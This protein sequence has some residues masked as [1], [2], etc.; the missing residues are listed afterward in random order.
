MFVGNEKPIE[1]KPKRL[2]FKH[3]LWKVFLEDWMIKVLALAITL[4]LWFGVT[5]LS[6]PTTRRLSGI[7]LT[8]LISN[9]SEITN[10]PLR[11]VDLVVSGDKR[12]VDQ[13]NAGDLAVSVDLSDTIPGDRVVQ[14]TPQGVSVSLPTG[15]KLD[16]L[17]P[18]RIAVKLEA[19]EEK[20]IPVQVVTEGAAAPGSAV[21]S[22]NA[23]PATVKVRGPASFIRSLKFVPTDKIDI[24]H[25]NSD[26]TVKQIPVNVSNPKATVLETVVDVTFSIREGVVR[27]FRVSAKNGGTSRIVSFD[28]VGPRALL[29]KARPDDFHVEIVKDDDGNDVPNILPSDSLQG[30][31]EIKN[32]KV[33]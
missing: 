21:Y 11:E 32:A 24:S 18:S 31:V 33:S 17:Q 26:F 3:I 30:S 13:I 16:E 15:V 1:K 9:D 4:G 23:V 22:Q 2:F 29:I 8:L 10:S 6:T 27:S 19:V 12:K 28:V 14:L 20:E 25:R 5:G 7:P